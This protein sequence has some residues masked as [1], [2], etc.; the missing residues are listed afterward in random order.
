MEEFNDPR[1]D[2]IHYVN[3]AARQCFNDE[4]KKH[5]QQAND[6]NSV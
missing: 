1:F 4:K 2:P 3:V 6:T 5:L